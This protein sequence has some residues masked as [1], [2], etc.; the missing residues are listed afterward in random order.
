MMNHPLRVLLDLVQKM[1]HKIL[2]PLDILVHEVRQVRIQASLP[3]VSFH[4]Y[5]LQPI[6]KIHFHQQISN[7]C[8]FLGL[9]TVQSSRSFPNKF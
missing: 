1:R 9:R 3:D 2:V 7:I 4:E 5:Q 6:L 8:I